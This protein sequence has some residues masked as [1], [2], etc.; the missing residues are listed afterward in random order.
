MFFGLCRSPPTFQAFMNH[1]FADYIWEQW[2]VIY[3]DDLVIGAHSEDDLNHKVCLVLECFCSLNLSLKLSKCEF[4]KL[5]IKFLGMIVGSGCI[6]MDPAKLSA[7]ATL[8]LPKSIKAVHALL[9]FCNF[10]RKFI[11]GFS[12]VTTPL[13]VLTQKNHPWEWG[14]AQQVAFST[15]LSHFQVTPVLHLPDVR[16]PFVVMMDASLL[17]SGGILMQHDDNGD[18]HPCAYLSQTFSSMEWNYDIYDWELLTVIHALDHWHHYLQGTHHPVTL[19]TDHKNLT[20]FH[21]P[22]KL[23]QWQACWMMFLQDPDLQFIHVPGTAMGPTDALSCLPNPDL[24]SDNTNVTLL[25]DNLFIHAIDTTLIQK[26]SSSSPT[27]PLVV[28]ALHNL[29]CGSPLFPCPSLANWH[30][31]DS[32]LYY[33]HCL[34]VPSTVHHNLVSSIHSSLASGHSGF[35]RTYSSLS[36]DYWWLGMSSFVCRFIT[37]CT[38]CQQMKVNTHPM[39]PTLA[40]LLSSCPHPFQQL[41]VDLVTGLPP[42]H[43]FDSLMVMVDHGLLKGVILTLCNKNINTKG[44]TELFFKNVFLSF[45]LHD[46]LILDHSPQF[47]S[48]FTMELACILGYDLKLSTTY[49]PQTDREM[50]WVNQEVETY[51]WM[52]CQGQ[53]DKWSEFIP[54]AEFAHN[55]ATHSS[56]QKSPFSLILGYKPQDYPKIGQTFLPSLEEWLSLLEKARDEVLVAHECTQQMM[57]EQKTSKFIPWKAGDKVWLEGKNLQLHYPMRKL[58][59]RWERPFEISYIISPLAYQLRLLLTWKIHNVF[60]TSLLSTYWETAKHGP[61]FI[62]PP[63][64]EID[65]EE[66]YEVADILS[67]W[68]SPGQWM[69]LVSWK[70]YS[71]VENTWEPEMNLRH[72]QTILHM[73]KQQNKL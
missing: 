54:M 66:E 50:E 14:P 61:N 57:K 17:A 34:Y 25:P 5:E 2:L 39:S 21:Q 69:Y 46:H 19:F 35:F 59:P 22:Q 62:N 15:L 23:S 27:D 18:L 44:V 48:T 10:Y 67:H 56:T 16:Q 1:N 47:T 28:T 9:G 53:P 30:F 49:H 33:R 4:G 42:S 58:P 40:P 24:S 29:S 37:G 68:G 55:S 12:N 7:I 32:K 63:P 60:H 72:A 36:R 38:L 52:F 65:G 13:T 71:A 51:L 41:S 3:M 26:I 64:E 11:P 43:G 8:P 6:R 70:G 31:N 20:Y 73:Y 45:G